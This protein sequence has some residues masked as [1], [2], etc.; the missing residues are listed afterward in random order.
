MQII[1]A[2]FLYPGGSQPQFTLA[3]LKVERNSFILLLYHPL[4]FFILPKFSSTLWEGRDTFHSIRR[5]MVTNVSFISGERC[6]E[7]ACCA[8]ESSHVHSLDIRGM[9]EESPTGGFSC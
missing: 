6:P 8:A 2:L 9:T 5:N 7:V 3:K 4:I 1:F